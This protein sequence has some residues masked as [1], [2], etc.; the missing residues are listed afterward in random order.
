MTLLKRILREKR[1]LIT[2][3]AMI[4][5]IDVLLYVFAVYPWSNKV[6]SS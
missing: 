5:A 6:S 2:T 4:L 3:V 1:T